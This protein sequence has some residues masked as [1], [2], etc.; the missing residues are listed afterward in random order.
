MRLSVQLRRGERP[1][2][3]ARVKR[4]KELEASLEEDIGD[5]AKDVLQKQLEDFD[6]RWED[7]TTKMD[8][9]LKENETV[10]YSNVLFRVK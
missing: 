7:V 5:E 10:R 2:E 4:A 9:A 8:K 1:G 6:S 3:I